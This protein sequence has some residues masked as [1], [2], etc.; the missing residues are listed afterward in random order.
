MNF[1]Q[2][3]D[4]IRSL[5]KIAAN[6]HLHKGFK[7]V[8]WCSDCGSALAEAEVEYRD[9]DSFAIDV[10]FEVLDE[11]ALFARCH[12]IPNGHGEGPL[13]VVIWTTT[14]WTLP[15]NQAVAFNPELEYA[16]VQT[17]APHQKERLI[18]AEGLLKETMD[19]W[20]IE[21]HRVIAYGRGDAFER[22]KLQHPFYDRQVPI[23]LGEHVTLDAG[24]GAVHTAPGH[25]LDDYIVGQR[26][27]IPV[28]NPVGGNGC[29]VEGTPMFEGQHVFSANEKVIDVLKSRGK[30][31]Q[32]ARLNHSYPCCWRHKTPIIFRAT[33]QWFIG[34][35]TNGLRQSAL[36][37]INQV[38]WMP[39]W[40]KARI[41]GMV[42]NRPDWCISRQRTWGVPITLFIHK[43]SEVAKKVEEKGIEAWFELEASGSICHHH[44][45]S[46]SKHRRVGC[47]RDA[48]QVRRIRASRRRPRQRV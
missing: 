41:Q 31:V 48:I 37:E 36:R 16:V 10:R 3:A 47:S 28:D 7:P 44:P 20:G 35:E 33:P 11:E 19:R 32:E 14:P 5:G 23:I 29:F 30:L 34:M 25:G 22:L 8:H 2:E 45:A 9:K 40:G 6:G 24:T 46:R 12:A 39:D 26:Y 17:E 4:I 1:Q 42:E 43:A 13:S 21:H 27:D 18:V 15:A 38:K